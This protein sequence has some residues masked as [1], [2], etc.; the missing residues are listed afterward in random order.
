[1]FIECAVNGKTVC[2]EKKIL[3]NTVISSAG[4]L[5]SFNKGLR[6]VPLPAQ[7]GKRRS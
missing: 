2:K 6:F 4:F 7:D 3:N 5:L 1:M